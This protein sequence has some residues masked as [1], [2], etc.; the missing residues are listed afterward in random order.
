[1]RTQDYLN[2][3]RVSVVLVEEYT[4]FDFLTALGD[5]NQ[6]VMEENCPATFFH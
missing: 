1:M 6:S 5:R 3:Y 2:R 4:G